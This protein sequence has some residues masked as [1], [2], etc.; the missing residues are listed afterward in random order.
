MSVVRHTGITVRDAKR[1]EKFYQN[2]FGFAVVK[3]TRESGEVIDNFSSLKRVDVLTVKMSDTSG[4]LIELLQYFSHA[5]RFP[6][7]RE[8]YHLGISH[9]AL[10]VKD[11]DGLYEKMTTEQVYF[12]Y[13][14]QVSPDGAVKIAFCYDCEGN[15]LELVEEI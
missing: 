3:K 8:I 5:H 6:T 7:Q 13:P 9:L 15:L 14:P 12:N 1:A 11:L 10:T 2:Y 4:N